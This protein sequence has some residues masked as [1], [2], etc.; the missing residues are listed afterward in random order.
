MTGRVGSRSTR[1][2]QFSDQENGEA[3]SPGSLMI[4]VTALA[5][6]RAEHFLSKQQR[7]IL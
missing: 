3:G 4:M 1:Y 2:D 6:G 7:K 5:G